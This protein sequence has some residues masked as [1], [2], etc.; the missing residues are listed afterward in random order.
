MFP[1]WHTHQSDIYATPTAVVC[2][3]C[4]VFQSQCHLYNADICFPHCYWG[5][6]TV[7]QD[8]QHQLSWQCCMDGMTVG[9]DLHKTKFSPLSCLHH[10]QIQVPFTQHSHWVPVF[11]LGYDHGTATSTTPNSLV[12]LSWAPCPSE[13]VGCVALTGASPV[14]TM[15][16][17]RVCKICNTNLSWQ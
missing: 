17:L 12:S 9:C 8:M 10:V 14:S 6:L 11:P 7:V 3:A 16:C 1:L 15:A 5:M 4:T 2:H 13:C